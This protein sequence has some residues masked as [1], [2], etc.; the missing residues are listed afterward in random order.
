MAIFVA[1]GLINANRTA[2]P[3]LYEVRK[4]YQNIGFKAVNLNSGEI[5]VVNKHSFTNLSEFVFSY[6]VIAD[7]QVLKSGKIDNLDVAPRSGTK[8]K[9][10]VA[11]D[12]KPQTEYFLNVYAKL[13]KPERHFTSRNSIGL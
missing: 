5:E 13:K 4:V 2:K 9:I 12:T 3:A 10:D 6:E 8:I 1:T 7:G 11:V